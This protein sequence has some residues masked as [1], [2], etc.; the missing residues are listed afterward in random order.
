MSPTA[1]SVSAPAS[2]AARNIKML[3]GDGREVVKFRMV[4][5]TYNIQDIKHA[6]LLG[7]IQTFSNGEAW[8]TL[9]GQR[10]FLMPDEAAGGGDKTESISAWPI[11]SPEGL[12]EALAASPPYEEVYSE[13][14]IVEEGLKKRSMSSCY[15][16]RCGNSRDC[17]QHTDIMGHCPR[18]FDTRCV[19]IWFLPNQIGK[20]EL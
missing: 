10:L 14:K 9:D 8:L 3:V 6:D 17:W 12:K 13:W 7:M 15:A 19:W 16:Q 18:C 20:T 11:M 1:L 4:P 5:F 2:P